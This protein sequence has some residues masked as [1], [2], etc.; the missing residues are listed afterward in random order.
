[1]RGSSVPPP[2][3][4]SPKAMRSLSLMLLLWPVLALADDKPQA[5]D[6]AKGPV[7]EPGKKGVLT[8]EELKKF[9]SDAKDRII[10]EWVEA[11]GVPKVYSALAK[12]GYIPVVAEGKTENGQYFSRYQFKHPADVYPDGAELGWA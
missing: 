4:S 1:M 7:V 11:V 5:A 3:G 9:Y 12:A 10:T 8:M 2:P 6:T